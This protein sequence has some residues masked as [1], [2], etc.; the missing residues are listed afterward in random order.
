MLGSLV[1]QGGPQEPAVKAWAAS[2][3]LVESA[4]SAIGLHQAF[5]SPFF[6][7]CVLLL[8]VCTALCAWQRTKAAI[9]KGRTLR[10]AAAA[11]GQSLTDVHDLGIECGSAL[12]GEEV[13]SLA[14]GTLARLGIKTKRR[15]DVLA[16]VSSPWSVWGSPIFHGALLAIILV[17][18]IGSL[19]R[20]EGLM[21]VPVGRAVPD[22]PDSYGVLHAGPL[23]AWGGERRIIRVDS[24]DTDYSAGGIDRGPTPSVSVLDAQGRVLQSQH[25][26]PNS[27]LQIGSL[28]IHP[29]EWGFA[30]DVSLLDEK[31]TAVST[32][33]RLVDVSPEAADGTVP[34]GALTAAGAGG[35]AQQKV[36][37][38]VPLL[39]QGGQSVVPPDPAAHLVVTTA[40]GSK[41]ADQVVAPGELLALPSGLTLRVDKVGFYARLSV[42]DDGTV[43]F[44]YAAMALAVLGLA[45]T[46]ASRQQAVLVTAREVDGTVR[47]LV[48]AHLWRNASTTRDEIRS[49]FSAALC[50]HKEGVS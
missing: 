22:T 48:S 39:R 33:T 3:P 6:L 19:Q 14:S 11:D 20:S 9:G 4:V 38:T 47:V 17:I 30:V 16:A 34:L 5:S 36:V 43:P 49:E 12:S 42:V 35:Q 15:D 10:R 31:G 13:L 8:G 25:I 46:V 23:H 45:L 18:L 27:P 24:F 21:G 44:L 29:A 1:P 32:A 28:T 2:N 50:G 7:A 41:V 37:V 40:D 26:Y